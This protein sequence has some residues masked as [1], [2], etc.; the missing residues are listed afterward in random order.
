MS[1]LARRLIFLSDQATANTKLLNKG[2]RVR[3]KRLLSLFLRRER[4]FQLLRMRSFLG[5]K[6]KLKFQW[7]ALTFSGLRARKGRRKK[8]RR[9][10]LILRLLKF[11]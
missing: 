2:A 10:L 4:S 6:L 9:K 11:T 5:V 3:F 7:K 8:I 1:G